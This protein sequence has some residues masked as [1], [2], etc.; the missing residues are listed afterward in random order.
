MRVHA[1]LAH[2]GRSPFVQGHPVLRLNLNESSCAELWLCCPK[3]EESRDMPD[4]PD[5]GALCNMN[6]A[7]DSVFTYL[8]TSIGLLQS[9]IM[10]GP[11]TIR[12]WSAT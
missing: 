1:T 7:G 9:S 5:A 8:A 10:N 3:G 2:G 11:N 12:S 4:A 6:D